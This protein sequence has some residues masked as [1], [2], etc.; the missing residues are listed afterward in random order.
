M[1]GLGEVV[2]GGWEKGAEIFSI[3]TLPKRPSRL[4]TILH[5][6]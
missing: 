3:K 2:D 6:L 4:S 1:Y 5:F